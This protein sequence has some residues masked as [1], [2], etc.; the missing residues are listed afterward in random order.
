M[1]ALFLCL[2]ST[3]Q[4]KDKKRHGEVATTQGFVGQEEGGLLPIKRLV[5]ATKQEGTSRIIF[6]CPKQLQTA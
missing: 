3:E 5:R 1:N 6:F 4:A 2:F